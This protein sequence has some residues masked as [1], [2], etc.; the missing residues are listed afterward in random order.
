MANI[1]RNS[2]YNNGLEEENY[3]TNSF[4]ENILHNSKMNF[5]GGW[6]YHKFREDKSG[7]NGLK[8]A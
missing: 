7:P 1:Y 4:F 5:M 2:A 3:Y 6:V 8:T